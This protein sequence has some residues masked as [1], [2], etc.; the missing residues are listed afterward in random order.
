MTP[1]EDLFKRLFEMCELLGKGAVGAIAFVFEA[2]IVV[3]LEEGLVLP[4]F[5]ELRFGLGGL[6]EEAFAGAFDFLV[7]AAAGD[8]LVGG[9]FGGIFL[10]AERVEDVDEKVVEA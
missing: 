9:P 5:F 7:R 1:E 2:E 8:F 3:N 6:A 4:G 10:E